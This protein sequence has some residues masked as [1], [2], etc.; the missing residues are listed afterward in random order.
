MSIINV[1]DA[2]LE[3]PALFVPVHVMVVPVVSY[4]SVVVPHPEEEAIPD[5]GSEM[6]QP[7]VTF[8]LFQPLLF[9]PSVTVGTITGG[10]LS[11]P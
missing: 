10:E 3:R 11:A 7:K 1:T 9:G 5:S 2:E 4:V 8:P 6:P